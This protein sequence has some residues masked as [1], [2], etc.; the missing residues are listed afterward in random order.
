MM[1]TWLLPGL[2]ASSEINLLFPKVN[3]MSPCSDGREE[4]FSG[5]N[6]HSRWV[7]SLLY[8]LPT[9]TRIGLPSERMAFA[10]LWLSSLFSR[11]RKKQCSRPLG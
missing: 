3:T 9:N 7:F 11:W 1:L 5:K 2:L 8:H 4:Q 10:K 6:N